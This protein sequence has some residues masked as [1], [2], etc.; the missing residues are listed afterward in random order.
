MCQHLNHWEK[1]WCADNFSIPGRWCTTNCIVAVSVFWCCIYLPLDSR[2]WVPSFI[3]ALLCS[4]WRIC[5]FSQLRMNRTAVVI[6]S[7]LSNWNFVVTSGT[8]PFLIMWTQYFLLGWM[9][10][11]I[12]PASL[13]FFNSWTEGDSMHQLYVEV[14]RTQPCEQSWH[15]LLWTVYLNF[16]RMICARCCLQ[17][18]VPDH[19]RWSPDTPKTLHYL[20][21]KFSVFISQLLSINEHARRHQSHTMRYEAHYAQH[22][23]VSHLQHQLPKS[24]V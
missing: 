22:N 11:W 19:L 15:P 4:P 24:L 6:S 20:S 8:E 5:T 21:E 3:N 10:C 23:R 9:F 17:R 18:K 13:I 14:L 2:K 7:A 1:R 16:L 12:L